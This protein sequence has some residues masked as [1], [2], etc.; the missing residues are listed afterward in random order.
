MLEREKTTTLGDVTAVAAVTLGALAA[1]ANLLGAAYVLR[2]FF[3]DSAAVDDSLVLF[4]TLGALTA[5]FAFGY[6]ALLLA[7]RD[8]T[9]RLVLIVAAAAQL[10][11][12]LLALLATLV[13]YDSGYGIHWFADQSV[14]RS[15]PVGLGGVPGAVTAIVNHNW[16]AAATAT[17][18]GAIVLLLAAV[19]PTATYTRARRAGVVGPAV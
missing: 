10:G 4:T 14:L 16:T 6:G 11:L 12:G 9:G 1:L 15:I 13:G 2:T 5:A 18:L 3:G 17:G 7:R 19:P 8:D